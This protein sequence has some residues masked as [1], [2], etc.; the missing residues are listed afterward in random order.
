[1]D[2][3][4][5]VF[6]DSDYQ[7]IEANQGISL[8]SKKDE[9]YYFI[10]EYTAEELSDYF[11]TDKT[12]SAYDLVEKYKDT[13]P[14]ITKNSSMIIWMTVENLS[15]GLVQLR[16]SVYEVEEDPYVFRKY[17]IFSTQKATDELKPKSVQEI[18]EFAANPDH[19][20]EYQN[21]KSRY[22]NEAYCLAAQMLIKLPFLQLPTKTVQLDDLRAQLKAAVGTNGELVLSSLEDR[23][24][25]DDDIRAL[26]LVPN[27]GNDF[28]QWLNS[29]L[30]SL[31]I[32][33]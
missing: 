32:K 28:D 31:G 14:G 20:Q 1:M 11:R 27:E 23:S 26:A 5:S 19:F 21:Y 9:E 25:E 29:T 8:Y 7:L 24:L 17:V 15:E 18:I 2:L 30:A 22:A 16:N 4:K 10:A 3:L 12:L 13:M 6:E 33:K